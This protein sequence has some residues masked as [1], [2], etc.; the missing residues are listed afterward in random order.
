MN[1]SR[2]RSNGVGDKCLNAE[3]P[4]KLLIQLERRGLIE[5]IS[6]DAEH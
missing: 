2:A 4:L 1:S 5:R 6:L 3:D